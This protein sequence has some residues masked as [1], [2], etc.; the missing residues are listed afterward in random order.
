M[1]RQRWRGVPGA[2][3]EGESG[4]NVEGGWWVERATRFSA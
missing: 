1:A 4:A 2:Q 3:K